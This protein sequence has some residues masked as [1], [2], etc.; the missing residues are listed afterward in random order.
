M[1]KLINQKSINQILN[2]IQTAYQLQNEYYLKSCEQIVTIGKCL[3]E[4]ESEL[5]KSPDAEIDFLE[6]LPFSASLASKYKQIAKHPVLSNSK[7]LKQLPHAL[8]T[9]YELSK[10]SEKDLLNAIKSG[11][12]SVEI[13]RSDATKFALENPKMKSM[14]KGAPVKTGMLI[15]FSQ[16]KVSPDCDENE[17]DEILQE[18]LK[19]KE[20][21]P[22]FALK[23]SKDFSSRYKEK[24]FESAKNALQ[25]IIDNQT[26]EKQKLSNLLSNA[27]FE[28]R[29]NKDILPKNYKWKQRLLKEVG[30]DISGE[31]RVSQLYKIVRSEG[32]I[33]RYT[34]IAEIDPIASVWVQVINFCEGDKSALAKLKEFSE[35][36][37]VKPTNKTNKAQELAIQMLGQIETL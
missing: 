16:L 8:S 24:L 35:K 13:T 7:N 30:I 34:P 33:T 22:S 11:E 15:S 3:I 10:A 19:I 28:S 23:I 31:V 1:V 36:S 27:I 29:K 25:Q 20:K 5:K 12:V 21:Y 32:I 6:K 2:K 14:G 17:Q 26:S 4:I 18:L 9:L 37:F